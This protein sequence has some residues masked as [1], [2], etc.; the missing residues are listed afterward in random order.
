MNEAQSSH[1]PLY[2]MAFRVLAIDTSSF[3]GLVNAKSAILKEG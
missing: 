1:E 3:T 2:I